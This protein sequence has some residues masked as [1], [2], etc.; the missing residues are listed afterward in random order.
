MCTTTN[1]WATH[2]SD[3]CS[4]GG[5]ANCDG[6]CMHG[7]ECTCSCHTDESLNFGSH[8]E[9]LAWHDD[10]WDVA[11]RLRGE[12]TSSLPRWQEMAAQQAAQHGGVWKGVSGAQFRLYAS[13]KGW[14]YIYVVFP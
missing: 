5:F 14:A 6:I 13:D 8:E 12:Y 7:D 9:A 3:E 4:R 2:I 1:H 11:L 10:F